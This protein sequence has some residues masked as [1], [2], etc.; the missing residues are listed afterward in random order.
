MTPEQKKSL[1]FFDVHTHLHDHRISMDTQ[2]IL[3]RAKQAGVTHMATCATMEE[4]FAATA[5]LARSCIIPCFGIHPWF[6]DTLSP[7]WESVLGE[8][9]EGMPSAVGETG[10]DFM[11]RG[12]DRKRQLSVFNTHLSL[13][14]DL[15]RPVNIHIRKAW[16]AFVHVLKKIGPLPAGGVVHSYSGS[17]DLVRVLT[18]H[19]LHISFS[20]AATRP[21][22]KKTLKALLAVPLDRIVFETDTPDLFPSQEDVKVSGPRPLNEPM[23][24]RD[25]VRICA[26]RRKM[27][28]E[29][30]AAHGYANA[31][32]LYEPVL[33]LQE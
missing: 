5:R 11:D 23:Y 31:R 17:A 27:P 18:T 14:M 2:G 15:R 24:V 25:I 20:G 6:L 21:R 1:C 16:D 22:A 29:Q 7:N 30:L 32:Q 4:N 3:L 19:N 9:L 12:A 26:A 33:P 8:H 10:L 13:A 28:V